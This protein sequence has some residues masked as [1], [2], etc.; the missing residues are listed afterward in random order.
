MNSQNILSQ[1]Q[2][3]AIGEKYYAFYHIYIKLYIIILIS[4]VAYEKNIC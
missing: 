3:L 1:L 2:R 4:K